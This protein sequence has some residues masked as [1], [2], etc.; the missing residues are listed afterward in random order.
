MNNHRVWVVRGQIACGRKSSGIGGVLG[1]VRRLKEVPQCNYA[2]QQ[3]GQ[4]GKAQNPKDENDAF[5]VTF[6]VDF[7]A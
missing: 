2:D 1:V 7:Q 3:G 6:A 4:Q 5:I